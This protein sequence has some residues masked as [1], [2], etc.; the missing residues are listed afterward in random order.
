MSAPL[1]IALFGP[2]SSGKST[3]AEQLANH[4]DEPWAPEFV[5]EFWYRRNGDIRAGHLTTIAKGQIDAEESAAAQA[6]RLVFCDTELITNTLWADLLFP[7]HCPPWVRTAARRRS[8]HYALYLFCDNDLP[9][10]EDVVRS[11]PDPEDRR[12][13]RRLWWAQLGRYHLPCFHIHGPPD[14]RLSLALRAVRQVLAGPVAPC[15]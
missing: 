6:R 1:R 2:E 7:G 9:F 8:H 14:A 15:R 13:C 4:F 5:R 10:E 12:R 11:F 3:L